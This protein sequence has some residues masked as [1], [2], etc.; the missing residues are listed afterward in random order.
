[1][2]SDQWSAEVSYEPATRDDLDALVELRIEAMRE[3]LQ[4]VGRFD[5][6]RARERFASTFDPAHT[7]H[8]LANGQ[9]VGFIVVKPH[10]EGL[11][12]DH[13]YLL[14]G[15]QGQGIG[16]HVLA[17]LL[18][19]ADAQRSPIHV[20]ALRESAANAFYL[21]HGFHPVSESEWDIFYRRAPP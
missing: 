11:L 20:G 9:R 21:R 5:P 17:E 13:L 7:R 3:S 14:P 19:D 18:A 8:V 12:L 4:R 10:A 2:S 1:M 15:H 16:G 6:A